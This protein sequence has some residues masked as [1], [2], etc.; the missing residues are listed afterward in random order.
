MEIPPLRKEIS[1]HAKWVLTD[2]QR[3]AGRVDGRPESIM[4]PPPMDGGVIK[5]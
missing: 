1:R 3:T 4:P 2:G 5:I